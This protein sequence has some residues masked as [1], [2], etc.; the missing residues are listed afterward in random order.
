MAGGTVQFQAG[1]GFEEV[2][3]GPGDLKCGAPGEVGR[4]QTQFRVEAVLKLHQRAVGMRVRGR[5][6]LHPAKPLDLVERRLAE[7]GAGLEAHIPVLGPDQV[8]ARAD[9]GNRIVPETPD[10]GLQLF[11][12]AG[13]G[14][15]RL[16][17]GAEA[18]AVLRHDV[19]GV[20]AHRAMRRRL[21]VALPEP[22]IVAGIGG[23]LQGAGE[24]QVTGH[25]QVLMDARGRARD[26]TV[27]SVR[28]G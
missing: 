15:L 21:E 18:P 8:G 27:L 26:R 11:P 12:V 28:C 1:K 10:S 17:R 9:A 5:E 4:R 22:A 24:G 19:A 20:E 2:V 23:Q 25:G 16:A 14:V 7:D 6:H 3:V 13:K